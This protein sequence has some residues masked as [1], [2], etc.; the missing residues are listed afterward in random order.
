MK[1]AGFQQRAYDA[2]LS[3]FGDHKTLLGVLATGGGKTLIFCHVAKRFT[4]R[5]RVLILAH[6]NELI[7]QAASKVRHIMCLDP[8]I[9]KADSYAKESSLFNGSFRKTPVIVSSV[10]TQISHTRKGP[11]R[12][13]RF[14]PGEFSLVICDEAHHAA[15]DSWRAVIGHYRKNDECRVLGVTA[16][17]DRAD[18]KALGSLFDHVAFEFGI[19]ELRDQGY[20]VPLRCQ[21]VEIESLD[22]SRCKTTAGDLNQKDM[23]AAIGASDETLLGFAAGIVQHTG[24]RRT[25]VFADS[26]ANATRL[27]QHLNAKEPNSTQLVVGATPEE[28]RSAIIRDYRDGAFPRLVGVGVPTEG[29]D[30][31]EIACVAM[32]RPTKSRALF[33]QMCGRGTRPVVDGLYAMEDQAE[34]VAAIAA[35]GKADC[36]I[37]DFVGNAGK[38][39]LVHAGSVLGGSY[40]E[41]EIALAEERIRKSGK[42]ADVEAELDKARQELASRKAR[43]G[44]G[45]VAKAKTRTTAIDLFDECD[46]A[47][48]VERGFANAPR[49][50]EKQ[51]ACLE[52]WG[53]SVPETMTKRQASAII[54]FWVERIKSGL[55]THKQWRRLKQFGIDPRNVSMKEA[56]A[57][58]SQRYGRP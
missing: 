37:L 28:E 14:N 40:T 9:E 32:C 49:A 18:K 17:P 29:F 44:S 23:A 24:D 19:A 33:A 41:K 54:G 56:S 11:R 20:L 5:G 6:R 46:I 15:S 57:V 7:E 22:L 42:P 13:E 51:V 50:S 30:V 38:H 55:C 8:E 16:T 1:L 3:A 21:F 35:S 52:R 58:L 4:E 39:K 26:V 43:E 12:M 2:T 27:T 36:V 34:R 48:V 10:Q 45:V 25:L 31:P 53:I 47:P